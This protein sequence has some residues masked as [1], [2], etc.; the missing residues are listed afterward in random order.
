M[1]LSQLLDYLRQDEAFMQNVTCWRT[2]P[3]REAVFAPF[4]DGLDERVIPALQK[5]HITQLYA[6]QADAF[7]AIQE[8]KD[9]VIV[10]P[11]AS[12]KT[13]CYNLP[14]LN[15]ILKN[16]DA[17]ALY[18][19][20][21][22]ALSADQVSELYELIELIGA[23]IKTYTYDGDTPGAARRAIRQAGHVVVTNPDMLHSGILPHHTKWVKLFE[24]LKYIVI[25]EIHSY[26]GV[27]GSNLANVLRRL[28]RLCRFYGSNPQFILCSAT[29][30]N[31]EELAQ[32]LIGRPVTKI[33]R[34]G[35]PSGEKHVI[36]YNPPVVNRQLGIRRGV[37]PETRRIAS[38]LVNNGIRTIVFGKSRL[39][40]EVLT[41]QLKELVKDPVGNSGRVRGYRGGYLP[42]ERREIE[43][44]LRAGR[45]DA[46]I[47]T[48]ALELGIDIGSLEACVM[49]GY[50][51]TIAST[52]QEAGR[53]GRRFGASLTILVA[54]SAA[55]DQFIVSHPDYFFG[56]SPENALLNPDN[57]YILLSHM[58]CSA[59][60]L[61]FHD[62]EGFGNAAGSEEMLAYLTDENILRHVGDTYHWSEE[63]F[64]ASEISLRTAMT[65]NF[66]IMDITDPA[67][68]RMVG[69]MD[70]FTAPMLLHEN[71]IYLHE[72]T[73]YQVEKLDFDACKAFI[74]KVDVDYY[75]DADLNVALSLLDVLEERPDASYGEINVTARVRMFKKMR[76]DTGENV[77]YGPVMLPETEMHTTALWWTVPDDIA[78]AFGKDD[79]QN[80]MLG[81]ANLMRIAAPLNLMCSPHD[82]AVAYQVKCT[83]TGKPTLILYDNCPGGVGLA[84]KAFHMREILLRNCLEIVTTCPCEKGCPSC[85]GPETEIGP[86]GKQMA[87]NLLQQL[88]NR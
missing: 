71:A 18:L 84:E 29:I 87:E 13:L 27:F 3:K 50:P 80:G 35:S 66:L 46:V 34:N 55:L 82:I 56:A 26:R 78:A 11:T 9:V 52:W 72:G 38:M 85:V 4:P 30:E 28:I 22:K 62:G 73:T 70:R 15:E 41:R 83:F 8:G 64:P 54:S 10:T 61:P 47:S 5:H 1:N 48:N 23:D 59:Y 65:E 2:L 57:I 12:G 58:K 86:T 67:H 45:I 6:H 74:R 79:L 77:G 14:V 44:G 7:S 68:I 37:L 17:R 24:N 63:D 69:E 88:L 31:P 49:C 81:I 21:T 33:D 20:P 19:F 76:F 32:T 39:Q 16:P 40:V 36:F 51:G 53:A 25:D 60:E 43:K 42:S 75:T